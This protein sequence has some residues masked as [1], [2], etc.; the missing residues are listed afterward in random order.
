MKIIKTLTTAFLIGC[1]GMMSL[2][3]NAVDEKFLNAVLMK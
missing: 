3:V 1:I 2:N